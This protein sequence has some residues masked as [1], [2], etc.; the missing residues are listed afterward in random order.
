M[1]PGGSSEF[2]YREKSGQMMRAKSGPNFNW[3]NVMLK[4]EKVDK[5]L[6][7][8]IQTKNEWIEVEKLSKSK[9]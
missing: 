6:Y 4:V 7:F 2:G 8:S 3:F 1:F 5:S 9:E